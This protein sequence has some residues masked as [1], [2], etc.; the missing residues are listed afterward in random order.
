MEI[1]YNKWIYDEKLKEYSYYL[2]NGD[3]IQYIFGLNENY[4]IEEITK[5]EIYICEDNSVYIYDDK[6]CLGNF[7]FAINF[8][9]FNKT[10]IDGILISN[11][12]EIARDGK[13]MYDCD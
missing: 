6:Y 13:Y 11:Y 3:Y 10:Q 7:N 2:E 1:E 12:K 9:Q 8:C 4:N 5:L